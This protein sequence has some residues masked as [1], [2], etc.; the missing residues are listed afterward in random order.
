MRIPDVIVHG[1]F[2]VLLLGCEGTVV[3]SEQKPPTAG[4]GTLV[5][6]LSAKESAVKGDE[7]KKP[8]SAKAL[9]HAAILTKLQAW[10]A[11]SPELD[12][13][14]KSSKQSPAEA[15]AAEVQALAEVTTECKPVDEAEVKLVDPGSYQSK[16]EVVPI[17]FR[18]RIKVIPESDLGPIAANQAAQVTKEG[19]VMPSGQVIG[20]FAFPVEI[21]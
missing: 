19:Q 21:K 4:A 15:G 13:A 12:S 7:K 11:A 20:A 9:K 5:A 8:L 18:E 3:T 17:D 1:M 16:G 10:Q 2:Q 6:S 14:I